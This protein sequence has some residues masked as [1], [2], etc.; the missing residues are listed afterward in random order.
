LQAAAIAM[1][2]LPFSLS[3]LDDGVGQWRN[4]SPVIRSTVRWLL[5]T[6]R[7]QGAALREAAAAAAAA[8]APAGCTEVCGRVHALH[9]DECARERESA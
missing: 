2:E 7:S 8:R 5:N 4:I 3:E 6:V 9:V 1:A